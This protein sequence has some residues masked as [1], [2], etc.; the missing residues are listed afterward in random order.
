MHDTKVSLNLKTLSELFLIN[1]INKSIYTMLSYINNG[2]KIALNRSVLLH[3][4]ETQFI[5]EVIYSRFGDNMQVNVSKMSLKQYYNEAHL[6]S[7]SLFLLFWPA[8][9]RS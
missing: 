2:M 4:E 3:K 8:A 7:L 5:L 9:H 6:Y 1:Q